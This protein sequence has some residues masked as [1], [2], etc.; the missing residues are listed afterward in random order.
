MSGH[1]KILSA[2]IRGLRSESQCKRRDIFHW[3]RKKNMNIYCLQE[4]HSSPDDEAVWLAEWGYRAVYSHGAKNSASVA[5]LFMNNFEFTIHQVQTDPNGRYII[6]DITA[7]NNRF[8]LVDI[9]GPNRDEPEFFHALREKLI[10]HDQSMILCGDWNVVTDYDMD[11]ANL[12]NRNNPKA[13][14]ALIDLMDEFCLQDV[15]RMHHPTEKRF[16]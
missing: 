1:L 13:R 6:M 3:L 8:T 11:T 12:R 2:N 10:T 7:N 5:I 15:W 16:T 4:M 14:N 9:Y